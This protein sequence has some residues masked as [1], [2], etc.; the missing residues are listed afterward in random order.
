MG[1]ISRNTLI[2]EVYN[3]LADM[4]KI[5]IYNPKYGKLTI[6]P[7]GPLNQL[8]QYIE[9]IYIRFT[10][11]K[12]FLSPEVEIDYII[13]IDHQ[14]S[15]GSINIQSRNCEGDRVSGSIYQEGDLLN[16]TREY[17]STF[18]KMFPSLRKTLS[19][20]T[21][22]EDSFLIF[23]ENEIVEPYTHTILAALLLLSEG[24]DIALTMEES[25]EGKCLVLRKSSGKHVFTIGMNLF[26]YSS[27]CG[28]EQRE[29]TKTIH[30][31]EAV[32]VINFFINNKRNPILKKEGF[33]E[34]QT[35]EEFKT[36]RFLNRP[37]F[38]IQMYIHHYMKAKK[39]KNIMK[40][41]VGAVYEI[42]W[43]YIETKAGDS[44][45]HNLA[46]DVFNRY[47]I[48]IESSGNGLNYLDIVKEVHTVSEQKKGALISFNLE[49]NQNIKQTIKEADYLNPRVSA[50]FCGIL[51]ESRSVTGSVN[52]M[53]T[54]LLGIVCF[55][56]Y[57]CTRGIY[58]TEHMKN[59]SSRLKEFFAK[60]PKLHL[61]DS[62]VIHAEWNRVLS[63]LNNPGV[64]YIDA[65]RTR[66]EI[67]IIN[68]I[69]VIAEL[70]DVYEP[71]KEKLNNLKRDL[72]GDEK[73]YEEEVYEY[74][75]KCLKS[76]FWTM[77]DQVEPSISVENLLKHKN[78]ANKY[79]LYGEVTVKYTNND[80]GNKLAVYVYQTESFYRITVAR[81]KQFCTSEIS[82]LNELANSSAIQ[83]ASFVKYVIRH[84]IELIIE[85]EGFFERSVQKFIDDNLLKRST[86]ALCID[87]NSLLLYADCLGLYKYGGNNMTLFKFLVVYIAKLQ[88]PT[89]HYIVRFASNMIGQQ[90]SS[91]QLLHRRALTFIPFIKDHQSYFPYIKFDTIT[92]KASIFSD[93]TVMQFL[94]KLVNIDAECSVISYLTSYVEL[95]GRYQLTC[96]LDILGGMLQQNEQIRLLSCLTVCGTTM[97][98]ICALVNTM[99]RI[100][101]VVPDT[102]L[103]ERSSAN[104][105]LLLFIG[106]ACQEKTRFMDIIK[107]CFYLITD[108]EALGIN[109][110]KECTLEY[111]H[112]ILNCLKSMEVI[113]CR[114]NNELDRVKINC[115]LNMYSKMLNNVEVLEYDE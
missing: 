89:T 95:D 84:Y 50:H 12:R 16:Y 112:N 37:S 41:I 14:R 56:A 10:E 92:Y 88:L 77:N 46:K 1:R 70:L 68:M 53:E 90:C 26:S 72:N 94:M 91:S 19:I 99:K 97:K 9:S 51:E 6:N 11:A 66:L 22:K 61:E 40:S 52:Y 27:E 24:L 44:A 21:T 58:T 48:S 103:I 111:Y 45:D 32:D 85:E 13:A 25:T 36:G 63:N 110:V 42:L 102:Q 98:H 71:E 76:L 87:V 15:K 7:D 57:D 115:I 62:K 73:V 18:L 107:E 54:T 96:L 104:A 39:T 81:L 64:S 106:I 78:S 33:V 93:K 69:C 34:P 30:L 59:A 74:I 105:I 20:E 79:D 17:Y 109:P 65:T 101:N 23:L 8:W 67:G 86:N 5:I 4:Y 47:F 83:G 35:Y 114:P 108:Q 60:Y 100:D 2:E 3:E 38:L 29:D 31:Q 80:V 82:K 49:P 113:L 55:F 75:E 43:E 28:A